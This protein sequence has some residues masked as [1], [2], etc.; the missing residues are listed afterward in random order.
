MQLTSESVSA[1]NSTSLS[2]TPSTVGNFISFLNNAAIQPVSALHQQILFL[3]AAVVPCDMRW[4][5]NTLLS[6][7]SFGIGALSMYVDIMYKW[8]EPSTG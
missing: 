2:T 3:C 1:A 8:V 5:F 7:Q 4:S 6:R